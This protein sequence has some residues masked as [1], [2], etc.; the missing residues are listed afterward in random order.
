MY[1]VFTH[2]K[3][4]YKRL[5]KAFTFKQEVLPAAKQNTFKTSGE[6]ED[7]QL[8]YYCYYY[9][10]GMVILHY[11][12]ANI[13]QVFL[14]ITDGL[15]YVQLPW[16]GEH[17]RDLSGRPFKVYGATIKQ[18]LYC[19]AQQCMY[20]NNNKFTSELLGAKIQP[21]VK[22]GNNGSRC[23]KKECLSVYLLLKLLFFH[24]K[25]LD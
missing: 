24:Q 18:L 21:N 3:N 12:C 19:A 2:S 14:G 4:V 11:R 5:F 7:L 25:T 15:A 8:H 6:S 10:Y 22:Q 23:Q 13:S 20:W 16:A 17:E 9:C 1:L